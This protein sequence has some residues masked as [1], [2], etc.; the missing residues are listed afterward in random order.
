MTKR[1][2]EQQADIEART[3]GWRVRDVDGDYW[4]LVEFTFDPVC[5]GM[6]PKSATLMSRGVAK[7]VRSYPGSIECKIVRVLRPATPSADVA[8]LTA[9]RDA[10]RVECDALRARCTSCESRVTTE[11]AYDAALRDLAKLTEERDE[12]RAKCEAAEKAL[13]EL[14]AD[15]AHAL[16]KI[17]ESDIDCKKAES[18]CEDLRAKWKAAEARAIRAEALLKRAPGVVE[19]A[20]SIADQALHSSINGPDWLA[21]IASYRVALAAERASQGC[22]T[23]GD[24]SAGAAKHVPP[25]TPVRTLGPWVEISDGLYIRRGDDG[26][27]VSRVSRTGRMWLG[28][29]DGG[30]SFTSED[31]RLT[32]E[33]TDGTARNRGWTLEGGDGSAGVARPPKY[34]NAWRWSSH[35]PQDRW[36]REMTGRR[37]V[38]AYESDGRWFYEVDYGASLGPYESADRA[39][40]TA[41]AH[42]QADGWT[43]E[44]GAYVEPDD[45]RSELVHVEKGKLPGSVPVKMS[46]PTAAPAQPSGPSDEE[47]GRLYY[48]RKGLP[49]PWER[50]YLPVR[51]SYIATASGIRAVVEALDGTVKPS[52]PSDEALAALVAPIPTATNI[53][54]ARAVRA[55][56][57]ALAGK[58]EK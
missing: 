4:H 8:R 13:K 38:T 56:V 46:Q 23:G 45:V 53:G 37:C 40:A 54:F 27:E 7:Y 18:E 39:K 11:R 6:N 48:E 58:G 26:R 28:G 44:G 20:L 34:A 12:W 24:G 29:V 43:L 9:E 3:I 32:M 17:E 25:S 31:M 49:T 50:A 5:V 33:R 22:T 1:T 36:I 47:L 10:A 41:D 35:A 2:T 52:G 51:Q 30:W 14:N 21:N 19:A 55:V 16:D 57:E 42:I 15:H